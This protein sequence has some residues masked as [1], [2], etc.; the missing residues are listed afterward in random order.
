M[1]NKKMLYIIGI[2]IFG[3]MFLTSIIDADY[4]SKDNTLLEYRLFIF[5]TTVIYYLVVYFFYRK[6]LQGK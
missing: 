1:E 5:G 2:V 4:Y 3:G 6:G